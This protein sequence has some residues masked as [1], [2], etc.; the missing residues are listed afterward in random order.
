MLYKQ[1]VDIIIPVHNSEKY[2]SDCLKSIDNQEY[3]KINVIIINDGSIDESEKII[4][5]YVHSS[6]FNVKYFA[7]QEPQGVSVARNKGIEL[8][9]GEFVTFVDSD[10]IILP[11]HVKTL[12]HNMT[13]NVSLSAVYTSKSDLSRNMKGK[14]KVL[15]LSDSFISVLSSKGVEGYVWNKLFRNKFLQKYHIQFKQ[16][17][18]MSEDLLFVCDYLLKVSGN[19]RMSSNQ[20]YYYRINNTS[21]TKSSSAEEARIQSQ[22]LVYTLIEEMVSESSLNPKAIKVFYE[23]LM[24]FLNYSLYRLGYNE[25]SQQMALLLKKLESKYLISF[26]MSSAIM[27]KEKMGY[28]YRKVKGGSYEP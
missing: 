28:L 12:V 19:M 18:V 23:K 11:N 5:S 21:V 17:I 13:G 1:Q 26:F 16:N 3:N 7:F 2:L 15:S 24:L 9:S 4:N 20:S 6:R 14:S 25:Q 27:S 22:Y 8:S 10:D